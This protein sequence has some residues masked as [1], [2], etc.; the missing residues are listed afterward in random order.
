[1]MMPPWPPS[2]FA[3]RAAAGTL[4]WLLVVAPLA[5]AHAQACCGGGAVTTP[6][7]L[8]PPENFAVGLAVR[9]RSNG[10][11]FDSDGHYAASAGDEQVLEQDLAA[12]L[13]VFSSAQVGMLIPI[14]QNHR[15]AT[16]IDQGNRTTAGIDDWGGGLGDVML[17]ARYDVLTTTPAVRPPGVGILAA[18][19]LPTGTPPDQ[20]HH[21]LAADATGA[22]TVDLVVGAN[23]EKRT[24]HAYVGLT[25]SA[26][27]RFDRT[28]S[29]AGAPAT[30][31][32]PTVQQSFALRWTV[33]AESS[34]V[35][36]S[37][38]ALGAYASLMDEGAATINGARDATTGLRSTTVGV[39]GVW[40]WRTR[41][42]LQ[43]SLFVDLPITALGRNEPAGAGLTAALVHAWM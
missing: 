41:W 39:A 26:M 31:E 43:G 8:G 13:R 21:A 2:R 9:A 32:P 5:R 28:I 30:D 6:T 10:G 42:R 17:T 29:V 23:V 36:D 16:G 7:R 3:R 37:E 25:A 1:M 4:G 15:T 40:P 24:P 27:H 33:I 35:F 19:T 14:L 22:G 34:Y 11:A 20:A 38:A 12:A 18:L